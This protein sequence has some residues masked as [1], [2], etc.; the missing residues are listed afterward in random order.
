MARLN[1]N[2]LR[3]FWV[4]AHAGSLTKAAERLNVSQS[5]LSIQIQKLEHQLG[6]DLF[7]RRGKRLHLTEAGHIAL[8]HADSIFAAGEELLGTLTAKQSDK[9][10][11]LRVGAV[12]TLS[13][14]FQIQLLGP[15]LQRDDVRTKIQSANT[16]E[17]FGLLQEHKID[18]LLSNILP[19]RD[20][21][22]TW[23]SHLIDQQPVSLIGHTDFSGKSPDLSTALMS[24]PL[25]LPSASSSIRGEFDALVDR[26]G[27]EPHIVA[28]GDDM[29][30]LRLL[31]RDGTGLAVIPPIVVKDEL[32]R[33][34]L[35]EIL[36]LPGLAELF[37]AITMSRRFPNPLIAEMIEGQDITA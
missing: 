31:A 20:E 34:T 37:Y 16:E 13:R 17:L 3:Y 2:H 9:I 10:Q 18:V 24:G 8:D 12:S 32:A 14:N 4:V 23:V 7:E 35:V 1:Y 22:S 33:G 28:E 25:I 30:M 19:P 11:S 26:L 15:L 21:K 5:A 6:Q 36:P 29:A 27:I